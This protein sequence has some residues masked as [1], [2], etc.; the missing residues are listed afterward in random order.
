MNEQQARERATKLAQQQTKHFAT[1][2]RAVAEQLYY[3]GYMAAWKEQ[4]DR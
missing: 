1:A 3:E 2:F 4:N